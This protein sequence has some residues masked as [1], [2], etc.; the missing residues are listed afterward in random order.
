MNRYFFEISYDGTEYHGWQRQENA[1]SVQEVVEEALSTV[2]K[3]KMSV[4]G[5]GRT[6]T[7]VHC[8]QQFFHLDIDESV[9]TSGLLYRLNSFLPKDISIG[10]IQQVQEDGHSRFSAIS[11]SY[12]YRINLR[13]SPFYKLYSYYYRKSPD[14]DSM[15][16]AAHLLI[17][18]HDFKAFSKVKT[19]VNN[20]KC[21]ISHA[22]WNSS[23]EKLW[24]NI[25]ANRFLRGMVRAIV[26]TLLQV[27]E[28][29]L[30]L[31]DFQKV[32]ESKDRRKASAAAP[33]HGLFLTKVVYPK[34]IFLANK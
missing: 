30:S 1:I 22:K 31:T 34:T 7:G 25:S 27:G 18:E 10:S 26:G 12:E 28:G 6:D 2:L 29:N 24:F 14:L 33:A 20:F 17:G 11:R 4:V 32:I 21:H 8:E 15:N 23:P 13:K 19:E 16:A 5:S 3:T 9:D